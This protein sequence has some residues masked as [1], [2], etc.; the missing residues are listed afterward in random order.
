MLT[1]NKPQG[2]IHG[3]TLRPSEQG[4]AAIE[5]ATKQLI[6]SVDADAQVVWSMRYI[7]SGPLEGSHA[8]DNEKTT[9]PPPPPSASASSG[10]GRGSGMT[11]TTGPC[12]RVLSFPA[13]SVDLAF[14]DGTIDRVRRAWTAITGGDADEDEFLVFA[15]RE[16]VDDEDE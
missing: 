11:M 16:G 3:S 6:E 8:F 7:Q 5:T 9:P 15:D 10:R 12:E 2:V 14:D 4:I 1:K 13:P